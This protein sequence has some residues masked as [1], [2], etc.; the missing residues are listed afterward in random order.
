MEKRLTIRS[1]RPQIRKPNQRRLLPFF[2]KKD[3]DDDEQE[4][5]QGDDSGGGPSPP[6][7]LFKGKGKGLLNNPFLTITTVNT[8]P[9]A[10]VISISTLTVAPPATTKPE[11][12]PR[13]ETSSTST[14]ARIIIPTMFP[15]PRTTELVTSSSTPE[16]TPP[17]STPPS[18]QPGTTLLTVTTTSSSEAAGTGRPTYMAGGVNP[19]SANP[20]TAEGT[21]EPNRLSSNQAVGV[22]I[23]AVCE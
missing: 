5:S 9:T 21:S 6:P 14:L 1:R 16:T 10:T 15:A 17:L 12:T 4:D 8:N 19:D 11:T 13:L 3:D 20:P 23:G 7:G 18:N 22:A 2:Q